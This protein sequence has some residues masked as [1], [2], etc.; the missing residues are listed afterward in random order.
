[1]AYLQSTITEK[2]SLRGST[3]IEK[4]SLARDKTP[5]KKQG[6]PAINSK[7]HRSS[8]LAIGGYCK[9][10][11]IACTH[12]QSFLKTFLQK[13]TTVYRHARSCYALASTIAFSCPHYRTLILRIRFH[14]LARSCYALASTIARTH[15]QSHARATLSLEHAR[16]LVLRSRWQTFRTF[17]RT[18]YKS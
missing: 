11:Y 14:K 9:Q 1:M 17:D 18:H 12:R 10:E 5:G 2:F 6:I 15:T 4:L 16:T 13:Q 3:T 7:P 8:I